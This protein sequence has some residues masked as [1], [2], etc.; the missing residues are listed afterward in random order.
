MN[1]WQ[2]V[3]WML[4]ITGLTAFA[5]TGIL[6]ALAAITHTGPYATAPVTGAETMTLAPNAATT[7]STAGAV[8][9]S[10]QPASKISCNYQEDT[11]SGDASQV[12][13]TVSKQSA[14]NGNPASLSVNIN[15]NSGT[16]EVVGY[17][18]LQ[19]LMYS[20]LPSSLTSSFKVTPPASSA[21][22]DYEYAYDVWLTSASN[23]RASNWNNDLELM[24]WTYVAGQTPAGSV[25]ATLADG[26]KVWTDGDNS[27]GIVS[28]VLPQ[29]KL[30]GTVNISGIISQLKARGYINSDHD[31]ILDVEYGI[32]APY[33]GGRTFTIDSLSVSG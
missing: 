10:A 3:A 13:Y 28:V 33:G 29:N 25:A 4:T 32:E 5:T 6:S 15:A 21:G 26:S 7:P 9:P 18:S 16:T 19:C 14:N 20:A 31:G 22:L 24:I 17:P 8:T 27:T 12:G 30:S 11:W 1:R 23:A 2:T